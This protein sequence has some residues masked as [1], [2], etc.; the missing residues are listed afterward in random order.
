MTPEYDGDPVGSATYSSS[1]A[2]FASGDIQPPAP[3][4]SGG[5][6]GKPDVP[7]ES[8]RRRNRSKR[9]REEAGRRASM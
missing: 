2:R 4:D 6:G 5:A 1:L 7:D 3:R 8:I 9:D